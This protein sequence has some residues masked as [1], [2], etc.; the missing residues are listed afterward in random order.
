MVKSFFVLVH[1]P[2]EIHT[3][4]LHTEHVKY[5]APSTTFYTKMLEYDRRNADLNS[6]LFSCSHSFK[7][8]S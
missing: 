3:S 2:I 8:K 5:E 7:W 1:M 6:N 4:E